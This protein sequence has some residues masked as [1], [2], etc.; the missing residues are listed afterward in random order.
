V[1]ELAK[2]YF[3]SEEN[4]QQLKDEWRVFKYELIQWQKEIPDEIK[5]ATNSK[6]S[7]VI[8]PTDFCLQ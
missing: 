8:I 6:D 2:H 4:C 7:P 5:Q 1:E 3:S